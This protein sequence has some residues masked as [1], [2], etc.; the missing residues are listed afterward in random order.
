MAV[1]D[2]CS[3][4]NENDLYEI[5]LNEHWNFVD[6]FIVLESEETHTGLKK[7][8]NFDHERFKPYASK[9]EYRSFNNFEIAMAK[10]PHL[11]CEIARREFIDKMTCTDDWVRCFFQ[12]NYIVE[13]L[14]DIGAKDDDLVYYSC[15]D[16]IISEQ[17]FL[18]V[19][20]IFKDK[21]SV[22]DGRHCISN[23]PY[24]N[25]GK[26]RPIV[27]FNL[28]Y[29]TYKFNVL[30]TFASGT[31]KCSA[32]TE[33]SNFKKILPSTARVMC[34]ETHPCIMNAGWHFSSADNT[35][36]EIVFRKMQSWAHSKDVFP[37]GR[38]RCDVKNPEEAVQFLL[39]EYGMSIPECVIPLSLETHPSYL[40]NNQEKFKDF[41]LK[42]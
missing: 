14:R 5:R 25:F 33:F 30:R 10:Y 24:T 4:L 36:G 37:D 9:I 1:Y 7:P 11:N 34:V 27:Y 21:E 28:L 40:V 39:R 29:Y 18:E 6:K 26:L 13:I 12:D 31:Y 23:A 20:E 32:I 16:E 15:C 35:N 3:F 17:A 22:Y 8:L 41:I 38:R 42:I 2:F 19:S